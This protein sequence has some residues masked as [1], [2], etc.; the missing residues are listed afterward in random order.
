MPET[1]GHEPKRMDRLERMMGLFIQDHARFD[2]QHRKFQAEHQLLLDGFAK[3]HHSQN[4]LLTA[5]V[6]LTDQVSKLTDRVDRVTERV[7]KLGGTVEMLAKSTDAGFRELREQMGA[8]IHVVDDLVRRRP[9][10]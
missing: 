6:I 2:E 4:Q 10:Q 1:N 8:L 9:L 3:L 5:Q 7:D